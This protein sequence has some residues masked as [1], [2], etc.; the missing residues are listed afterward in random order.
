MTEEQLD[1]GYF[2]FN[3]PDKEK[4]TSLNGEGVWGWATQEEKEKYNND[5]YH[6]KM[7][8]ILMNEPIEYYGRLHWGD[9]VILKCHGESRPTLDSEWVKINLK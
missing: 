6:G 9:E 4:P 3:I 1:A 7:T 2:K 5:K 8:A